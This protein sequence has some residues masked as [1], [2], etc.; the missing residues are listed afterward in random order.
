MK[1]LHLTS[2]RNLSSIFKFGLIPTLVKNE[3]HLEVF[4]RGGLIGDRVTYFWSPDE[5][6]NTGKIIQD[7][8]YTKYYIHARNDFCSNLNYEMFLNYN[9]KNDDRKIYGENDK[10]ALLE[11]SFMKEKFLD[12]TYI[13]IQEPEQER[14]SNTY[15]MAEKYAHDNKELYIAHDVIHPK[16]ITIHSYVSSRVYKNNSLGV[17]LNKK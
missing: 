15:C 5:T 10:W 8:I 2:I 12:Q 14:W 4:Q 11:I 6:G 7:F 3:H 1:L 9:W 16:K 13:H 17:T